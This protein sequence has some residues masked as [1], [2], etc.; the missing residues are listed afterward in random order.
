MG[1]W[2]TT[3]GPAQLVWWVLLKEQDY[4]KITGS[5]IFPL[6]FY[7]HRWLEH[8]SFAERVLQIWTQ[9]TAY[10]SDTLE[11]AKESNSYIR[12]IC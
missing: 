2:Y 6:P 10:I 4:T 5:D 7:G 12:N 3:E 9:I 11:E 8:K 1:N